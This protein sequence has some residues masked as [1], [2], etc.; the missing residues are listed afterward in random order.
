MYSQISSSK[1]LS[2]SNSHSLME[3]ARDMTDMRGCFDRKLGARDP[4]LVTSHS[5][6]NEEKLS[7]S[8]LGVVVSYTGLAII[9]LKVEYRIM[10]SC[11]SSPSVNFSTTYRCSVF[12]SSFST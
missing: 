8:F 6:S 1:A 4:R 2:K 10:N 7:R 3:S 12:P 11:G 9:F 5:A